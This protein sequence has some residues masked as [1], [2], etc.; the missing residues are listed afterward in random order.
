M[1]MVRRGIS[2]FYETPTISFPHYKLSVGL[3]YSVA[4]LGDCE[5]TTL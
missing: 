5:R 2:T 1:S 4:T 3:F